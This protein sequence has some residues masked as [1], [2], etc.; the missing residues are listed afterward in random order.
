VKSDRP[1]PFGWSPSDISGVQT[2]MGYEDN[3]LRSDGQCDFYAKYPGAQ[4]NA[5]F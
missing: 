3:Y 5:D 4:K 1:Y 2:A